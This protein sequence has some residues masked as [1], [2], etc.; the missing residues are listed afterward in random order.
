MIGEDNSL[1]CTFAKV[2]DTYY[3]CFEL[4]AYAREKFQTPSFEDKI[5]F[6]SPI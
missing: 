4:H 6:G 5:G 2:A 3:G 1:P